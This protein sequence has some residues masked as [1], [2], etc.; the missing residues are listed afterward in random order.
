MS[1]MCQSLDMRLKEASENDLGHEA[2]LTQMIQDEIAQREGNNLRRRLRAAQ[3]G[4]EKTL[5]GFDFKFNS[6]ALPPNVIRD[7][8]TCRFIDMK[9]NIV[10]AGPPG[11][12]KTHIAKALGHQACRNGYHVLFKKAHSYVEELV[13]A[14]TFFKYEG[15]IKK[16][17]QVDLLILDDFGF[18]KMAAKEAE[19]FYELIDGRLGQASTIVT[20]NRPAEDWIHI[21]PDAVMGGAILDRLV[22]GARKLISTEAP[23]FRKEGRAGKYGEVDKTK[24][25]R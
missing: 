13:N 1:G 10:I 18:R 19:I 8:A 16:G 22:S 24:K 12:G 5:E 7:F 11:I 4:A 9:E 14:K 17:I 6:Q 20:S 3:F 25:E 23:S 2:F 21:F 15:L